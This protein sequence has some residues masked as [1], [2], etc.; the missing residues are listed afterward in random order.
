MNLKKSKKLDKIYD[1][2]TKLVVRSKD[3]KTVI[4]RIEDDNFV[5]L[6]QD[7]VDLC[8]KHGYKYDE[9]LIQ[10]EEE[11]EEVEEKEEK[12]EKVEEETKEVEEVE[13]E[14]EAPVEKETPKKKLV[15]D[16]PKKPKGVREEIKEIKEIEAVSEKFVALAEKQLNNNSFSELLEKFSQSAL[17]LFNENE[18]NSKKKIEELEATVAKLKKDLENTKRINK[19]LLMTLQQQNDEA[20]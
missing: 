12:E 17:S 20:V 8:D 3:D 5:E 9:S 6:D 13:E 2:E 1:N 15:K 10:F 14:K 19:N 7:A 16:E 11:V 18:N 4:G